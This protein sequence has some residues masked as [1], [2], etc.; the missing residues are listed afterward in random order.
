MRTSFPIVYAQ[1]VELAHPNTPVRVPLLTGIKYSHVLVTPGDGSGIWFIGGNSTV[2]VTPQAVGAVFIPALTP[3]EFVSR[4]NITDPAITHASVV[5]T[6]Q[7]T[8]VNVLWEN[9]IISIDDVFIN[10]HDCLM[11]E[12]VRKYGRD[13]P[14]HKH[15][16]PVHRTYIELDPDMDAD[17]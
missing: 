2:V 6:G 7:P 11:E 13:S 5:T 8:F 12:L 15:Y 17:V 16:R 9:Q 10:I 1:T 4:R 14:V 3:L